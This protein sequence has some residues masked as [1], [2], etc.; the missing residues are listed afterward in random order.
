MY[1]LKQ[2]AY[3][4]SKEDTQFIKVLLRNTPFPWAQI[5]ATTREFQTDDRKWKTQKPCSYGSK[6]S[7]YSTFKKV[8]GTEPKL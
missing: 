2:I 4:N 8:D 1:P 7:S 6:S 5:I 3:D